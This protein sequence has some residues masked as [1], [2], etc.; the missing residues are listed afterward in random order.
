MFSFTLGVLSE[1][2]LKLRMQ[3]FHRPL[4]PVPLYSSRV[5]KNNDTFALKGHSF[6]LL[7][8]LAHVGQKC[9]ITTPAYVVLCFIGDAWIITVHC[10]H[11]PSH[12]AIH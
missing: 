2:W 3:L 4:N 12:P 11:P 10:F 9:L 8:N 7:L 5:Y 6:I 1:P